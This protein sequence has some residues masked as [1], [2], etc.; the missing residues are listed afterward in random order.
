MSGRINPDHLSC[1]LVSRA[2]RA[3]EAI[4]I[5]RNADADTVTVCWLQIDTLK[6]L[7]A[8][9]APRRYGEKV[10]LEAAVKVSIG[11]AIKRGRERVGRMRKVKA[12]ESTLSPLCYG[13]T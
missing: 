2:A 5:A 6:W 8:N 12:V 7:T 3:E 10:V 13:P 9:S 4:H 11:V 1:R